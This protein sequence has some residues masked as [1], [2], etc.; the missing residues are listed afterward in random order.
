M[1]T[2]NE[3]LSTDLSTII[4][5]RRSIIVIIVHFGN[6]KDTENLVDSLKGGTRP[7]DTIVVIDNDIDNIGY[8]AGL[9]AG[10]LESRKG[11]YRP[12]DMLILLNNDIQVGITFVSDIEEWWNAHGSENMIAG[13]AMGTLSLLSGRAY[14]RGMKKEWFTY[15]NYVHGSCL[16]VER[17]F[18]DEI[19]SLENFFMYWEDVSMSL[20]TVTLGGRLGEIPITSMY[21]DDS[22]GALSDEKLYYLVRNGAYVLEQTAFPWNMY[23]RAINPIRYVYHR[24]LRHRIV[25]Q[26]LNDRRNII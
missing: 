16:V 10:V 7:P 21:H 25:F 14:V 4:P 17:A 22:A 13:P 20:K 6:K 24:L 5:Q 8:I 2:K 23:W 19:S 18:F 15:R 26:A 1:F 11:G 9:R 3:R 12:N